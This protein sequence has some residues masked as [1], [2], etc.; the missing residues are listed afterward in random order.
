MAATAKS[1][2]IVPA[3]GSYLPIAAGV[4]GGSGTSTVI[5]IPQ[6]ELVEGAIVTG[7]TGTTA[8]YVATYSGNTFTVTHAN[9]DSFAWIAFGR[10]KV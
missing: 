2:F 5:T 9:G 1:P 7:D 10:V 8:M 6:F 4:G 3:V